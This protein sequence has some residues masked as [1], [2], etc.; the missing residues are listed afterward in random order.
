M[1]YKFPSSHINE[2]HS[3]YKN[4]ITARKRMNDQPLSL[5]VFKKVHRMFGNILMDY[6]LMGREVGLPH[7]IGTITV[8]KTERKSG[9]FFA[10]AYDSINKSFGDEHVR[11]DKYEYK[12]KFRRNSRVGGKAI[13][14]FR[15]I[16]SWTFKERLRIL[17]K[18]GYGG[19][20]SPMSSKTL[21]QDEI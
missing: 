19:R 15:F 6:V 7:G 8:D 11:V 17:I 4:E 13:T 20:Y 21:Q 14:G 1:K 9:G 3:F 18:N 5:E 16:P 10:R 12:V 2:A